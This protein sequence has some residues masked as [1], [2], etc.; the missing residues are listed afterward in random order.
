MVGPRAADA[1]LFLGASDP[2]IAAEIGTVT[3]LNGRT[4]VLAEQGDAEAPVERAA[5]QAGA[6]VEFV[7][8]PLDAL[9]FDTA[10]SDCRHHRTGRLAA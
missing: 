3:R 6:L 7:T 8:A 1:V 10:R 5:E 9:P 2:A 4:V